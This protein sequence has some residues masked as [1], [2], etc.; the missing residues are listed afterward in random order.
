[1]KSETKKDL[2]RLKE[3]SDLSR[4]IYLEKK[5]IKENCLCLDKESMIIGTYK[6]SH[7]P[8][9]VCV[10]CEKDYPIEDKVEQLECVKDYLVNVLKCPKDKLTDG[11]LNYI[12]KGFNF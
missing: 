4:V 8:R 10:V 1:M 3:L 2:D 6:Y 7:T 9:A 5:Q 11:Y 12:R